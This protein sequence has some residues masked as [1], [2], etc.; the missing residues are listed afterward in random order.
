MVTGPDMVTRLEP[1][2]LFQARC[3]KAPCGRYAGHGR[4]PHVLQGF[5]PMR[6]RGWITS[7]GSDR[8]QVRALV[9][10]GGTDIVES[11]HRPGHTVSLGDDLP[12]CF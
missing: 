9:H 7:S 8:D 6:S 5:R 4:N 10:N 2:N 3:G 12:T 1:G 11:V